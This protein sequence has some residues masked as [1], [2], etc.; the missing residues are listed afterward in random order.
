MQALSKF[1]ENMGQK[2]KFIHRVP[3]VMPCPQQDNGIDCG[4]FTCAFAM[5][6]AHGIDICTVQQSKIP[7]YRKR[8][9]AAIHKGGEDRVYTLSLASMLAV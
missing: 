2:V 5:A 4:V 1:V 8:W 7:L 9:S 3:S 6:L